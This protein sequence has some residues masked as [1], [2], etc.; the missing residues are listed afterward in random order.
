LIIVSAKSQ[1]AAKCTFVLRK[2][3]STHCK[4]NTFCPNKKSI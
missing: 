3:K 4:Q 1:I 2:V